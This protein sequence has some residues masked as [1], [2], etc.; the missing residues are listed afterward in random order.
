[1]D[2]ATF[3][4]L[5]EN[6]VISLIEYGNVREANLVQKLICFGGDGTTVF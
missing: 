3:Y 4:K 5:M 2:G 1:V 6:I